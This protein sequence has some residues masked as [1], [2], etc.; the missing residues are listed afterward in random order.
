M[1]SWGPEE[2]GKPTRKIVWGPAGNG[3]I[4][5]KIVWGPEWPGTQTLILFGGPSGDLCYPKAVF[6]NLCCCHDMA[7]E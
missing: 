6:P 5:P 2:P 3:N 7:L 4:T 1:Q